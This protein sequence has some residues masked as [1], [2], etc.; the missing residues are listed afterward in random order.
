[1]SEAH[2]L[3]E[4]VRLASEEARDHCQ[5]HLL[6]EVL[7][8]ALCRVEDPV[9]IDV[10]TQQNIDRQVLRRWLR[11][12]GASRAQVMKPVTGK[13][14][15]IS[16]DCFHLLKQARARAESAGRPHPAPADLLEELA[17]N[18]DPDVS[19]VLRQLGTGGH[20]LAEACRA[21]A[22]RTGAEAPRGEG[23]SSPALKAFGKDYRELARAKRIGPVIGRRDEVLQVLQVLARKEKNNPVL[24]GE[25][26]VG[27]TAVVEAI[28]LRALDAAAPPVIKD[29]RIVELS[30]GSLVAG[31][32]HRGDFE[33]RLQA[34]LREA[35]Q[36]ESVILFLDEIHMLVGAGGTGN[37]M[38]AANLLK[39][40]LARGQ[41]RLIGAT[42]PAE[43]RR[44]IESDAAL[45]R[46]FQPVRVE[47]PTPAETLDILRGL[48]ESYEAHHGL[49][50]APE[51][52]EAAVELTVR[53]VPER[54]L[55]DKA[56]DALDQA[57]SQARIRTLTFRPEDQAATTIG[58]QEVAAAVAAWKGVPVGQLAADERQRLQGLAERLRARVK[59]QDEVVEAVTEAVQ[60][61]Y[62]GLSNP[63][64]PHAVF[65]LAG[66]TGVGKTEL[67]RALAEQMFG[68]EAALV[69]FDMSEY[70]EAHTVS[71]LVGAPPGYIGH[72][73]GAQLVDAVRRRPFC[74]VLLDEIEKAHPQVLN[75]F[76]QVFD[77]GRLT[78]T[79]GRTADFRNTIIIMTSN[80]GAAEAMDDERGALG[81]RTRGEVCARLIPAVGEAIAAHFPPELLGRLTSIHVLRPL[82][83]DASRQIAVRHVERLREQLKGHGVRLDL[84]DD[85]YD[86]LVSRGFSAKLGARPLEQ[87]IDHLLRAPI[88]RMLLE[89]PATGRERTLSVLRDGEGLQLVW[90]DAVSASR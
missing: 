31:A 86:F 24:V 33:E 36:D 16:Q 81:L 25:P 19:E 12:L 79:K 27:K 10:F 69:R 2:G 48:K 56:R 72:D 38:D 49:T 7:W 43:Y 70:M 28:A 55:P 78:D 20:R 80:L 75:L 29:R 89:R 87:T 71:R 41:L 64:R 17:S 42:T 90:D 8:V 39:P 26:G 37:A 54:R 58:R 88:A 1:M 40:A 30:L 59:G 83:R 57:A 14:V 23:R 9:L 52:L 21:A 15:K 82:D 46:R 34:V 73:D 44:W 50:F 22:R 77:D 60:M 32:S 74:V 53:Y 65:L 63:R 35:E 5:R 62:V 84:A 45:E 67:A 13:D 6:P 18:A 66:P 51:A 68:D 76:L 47:E 11:G 61:A 3:E 85:V 4:V